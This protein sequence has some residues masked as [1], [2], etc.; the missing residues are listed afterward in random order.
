MTSIIILSLTGLFSMIVGLFKVNEKL[1][2]GILVAALMVCGGFLVSD[3]N[4]EYT[5]FNDMVYFDN[6]ALAFSTVLI[7]ITVLVFFLSEHH[8]QQVKEYVTEQYALIIF[9]LIGM[10][11]IVSFDHLAML[12]VGIEIMSIPLY[13]LAGSKK[14]DLASNEASLKYF[15]MGAFATGLLLMG[16]TLIYGATGSFSLDKIAEVISTTPNFIQNPLLIGG[17]LLILSGLGFKVS[18]APFHFWT[19]DVYQGS[20]TWV[21]SFMSTA[22]KLAG[23]AAFF[24]LFTNCFLPL[25]DVWSGIISVM[26]AVTISIGGIS[27]VFQT[28]LKRILAYSSISHAGYMLIVLLLNNENAG[29]GLLFYGLTYSI[30]SIVAFAIAGAVEKIT[31]SDSV[32]SFNGLGKSHPFLAIF[33]TLSMLSLAGIPLTG[34]F[35]AKFYILSSGIEAGYLW[36]ML[37][38]IVNAIIGIYYYFKV[39]IAMFFKE[40]SKDVLSKVS[41]SIFFMVVLAICSILTVQ[42]GLFPDLVYYLF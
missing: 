12:F 5:Y 34:G 16:I 37:I 25:G 39:I 22:V 42:L 19:P 8:F 31:G 2:L 20:P 41:V 9:S 14:K 36:L 21:T 7:F 23:F 11:I 35:F 10:I 30:A 32:D 18:A 6:Y 38:A 26:A 27:A 13:I 1:I 33:M 29:N 28:S 3:W 4:S 15:L 17:L 24:R 40:D